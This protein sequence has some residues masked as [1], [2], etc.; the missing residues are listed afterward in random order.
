MKLEKE[1]NRTFDKFRT[2]LNIEKIKFG[3]SSFDADIIFLKL[4]TASKEANNY[5]FEKSIKSPNLGYCNRI[6]KNGT[7]NC[8]SLG[9][10]DFDGFL[11]SIQI[12][13]DLKIQSQ[14]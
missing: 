5:C 6:L 7:N 14:L 2:E 4:T 12:I 11:K 3:L 9:K 13:V 1:S 10:L 8:A